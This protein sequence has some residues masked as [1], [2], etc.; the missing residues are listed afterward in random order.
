MDSLRNDIINHYEFYHK[1]YDKYEKNHHKMLDE[2]MFENLNVL[3]TDTTLI[4]NPTIIE[5]KLKDIKFRNHMMAQI[6]ALKGINRG[7]DIDEL[8]KLINDIEKLY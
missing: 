3:I 5:L 8:D 1:R 2:G 4:L 6:I 7:L